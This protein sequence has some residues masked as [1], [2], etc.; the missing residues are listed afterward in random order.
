VRKRAA[1]L[2]L[3]QVGRSSAP[4]RGTG[5]GL[6]FT[7]VE[8]LPAEPIDSLSYGAR[9]TSG[10]VRPPVHPVPRVRLWWPHRCGRRTR[11]SGS[12]RSS[13]S[14]S[15][16]RWPPSRC[17]ALPDAHR[18]RPLSGP[19]GSTRRLAPR[20]VGPFRL[21][22]SRPRSTAPAHTPQQ[23]RDALASAHSA[24]RQWA[25]ADR[26]LQPSVRITGHQLDPAQATRGQVAQERQ[27][28]RA[29]L[30][31]PNVQPSRRGLGVFWT[32]RNRCRCPA[33]SAEIVTLP[34]TAPMRVTTAAVCVSLCVSTPTT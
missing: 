21:A 9:L 13:R 30:A 17:P 11:P 27:P 18:V 19:S 16:A 28:E 20:A 22:R 1:V 23:L 2:A 10:H 15:A 26:R 34:S 4:P 32:N 25:R 12:Q 7:W 8:T 6:R 3:R 31:R 33:A 29:T 24:P 5:E 14:S